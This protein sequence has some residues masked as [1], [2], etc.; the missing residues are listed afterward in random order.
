[1]SPGHPRRVGNLYTNWLRVIWTQR[2]INMRDTEGAKE[3]EG[4]P[5]DKSGT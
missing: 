5:L 3:E 4:V 1:M 2:T